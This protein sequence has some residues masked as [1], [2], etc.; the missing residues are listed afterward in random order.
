LSTDNLLE[1][2]DK[3]RIY[4]LVV[5]AICMIGNLFGF[6]LYMSCQEETSARPNRTALPRQ[7]MTAATRK[8]S[9]V[10]IMKWRNITNENLAE[11]TLF[12]LLCSWLS[13]IIRRRVPA[14]PSWFG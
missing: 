8:K 14:S 13:G 1:K 6:Y 11:L 7:Y 9:L 12:Y 10:M 5:S 4:L 2:L 3:Y